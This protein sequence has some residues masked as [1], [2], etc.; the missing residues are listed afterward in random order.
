MRLAEWVQ[1]DLFPYELDRAFWRLLRHRQA[2]SPMTGRGLVVRSPDP[3]APP[4]IITLWWR[5]DEEMAAEV[6]RREANYREPSDAEID[7]E[8][9]AI[10]VAQAKRDEDSGWTD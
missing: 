10:H 9:W 3:K 1:R 5:T 6:K 7:A 2:C 8:L 4:Q